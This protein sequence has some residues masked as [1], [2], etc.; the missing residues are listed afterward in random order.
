M[1]GSVHVDNG[2]ADL[3]SED[4]DVKDTSVDTGAKDTGS[5]TKAEG[6]TKVK[7]G[8]DGDAD[9]TD[10][11]TKRDQNPESARVQ[12]LANKVR[13]YEAVLRS[14]ELLR[15]FAKEAGY[16]LTEAKEVLEDKKD[17]AED[18]YTPDKL[19]TA[20]DLAKALT[21]LRHSSVKE[22][23]AYRDKVDAL[24]R[25]LTILRNGRQVERITNNLQSDITAARE[26]YPVLNPKD[27]S[28]D[29]E[30]EKE[31]GEMFNDLDYDEQSRSYRGNYSLLK[32]TDRFMK[33]TGRAKK[34]GSEEAQ[35]D[36]VIKGRG[37]VTTGSK[38]ASGGSESEDPGT[39]IAQRIAKSLKR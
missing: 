16:S 26:K 2:G 33:A 21:E 23:K 27:P 28:Y 37:K 38:P 35:T 22:T 32:L 5:S 24:E 20:D 7:T 29:P 36:I 18:A 11:G 17:E 10:K 13:D 19:Q 14:P 31:I 34:K 30:L 12:E 9:I 39:A 6:D 1:E 15:K 25:E 4:T 3:S 8:D